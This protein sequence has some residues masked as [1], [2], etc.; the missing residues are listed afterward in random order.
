MAVTRAIMVLGTSSNVG[1]SW[2]VTGLCALLH[3]WGFSVA[4]FKA[5]GISSNTAPARSPAGEWGEIGRAQATQ[6]E[7]CGLAPD[8]DMN[9]LLIKPVG[10]GRFHRLLL[11]QRVDPACSLSME[12]LWADVTAAYRRTAAHRDFVVV[13]GSGS[14]VELNLLD[15]DLAN[16]RLA[17][18]AAEQARNTGGD[19]ACLLVGDIERGGSSPRWSAPS[20]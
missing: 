2:L 9:P 13:E 20:P 11:G 19:A 1:K 6:A 8:V 3:R 15:Q 14:P 18:F 7:A 16:G 4:P 17:R 12:A 5:L 10:P